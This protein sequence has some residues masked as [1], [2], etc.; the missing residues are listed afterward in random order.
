MN[1]KY[2]IGGIIFLLL[3][4]PAILVSVRISGIGGEKQ[5]SS[6]GIQQTTFRDQERN[7]RLKTTIWYPAAEQEA[8]EWGGN[9]VFHGLFA[10]KNADPTLTEK[11]P[12]YILVHGTFGSWR[13]MPWL[14]DDL[15]AQGAIVAAADHP[16]STWGDISPESVLR[17]WEQPEDVSFLIDSLLASDFG[18]H[19]DQEN[20]VVVGFSLGGFTAMSL[21]GTQ[22]ELE[23]L[24]GYCTTS[25]EEICEYFADA[26]DTLD[27]AHIGR[28]NQSY[29]DERIKTAVALAPGFGAIFD[30]DSLASLETPLLLIGAE[31]DINVP[32]TQHFHPIVDLL[33]EHSQYHELTE[34]THFSFFRLCKPGAEEILAKDGEEFV[35]DDSGDRS[36]EELHAETISLITGFVAEN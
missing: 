12:L 16:G 35:C 18:P 28:A 3:A 33:P 5:L 2:L 25:N 17:L 24:E 19:I 34:A 23:T 13:N 20:I 31:N 1:K 6:I 29:R 14:V 26:W 11:A 9:K 8:P 7:R 36:R 22:L 10:T 15:V 21:A 30:Q 27:A 4:V 32:P